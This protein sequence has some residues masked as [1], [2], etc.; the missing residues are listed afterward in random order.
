MDSVRYVC[1][2]V[3]TY[4]YNSKIMKEEC[5]NWGRRRGETGIVGGS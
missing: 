3:C 2:C 4:L 5:V 1:V